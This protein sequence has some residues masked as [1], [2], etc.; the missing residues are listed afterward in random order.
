MPLE[1]GE[2]KSRCDDYMRRQNTFPDRHFSWE[3]SLGKWCF[4]FPASIVEESKKMMFEVGAERALYSISHSLW[5]ETSRKGR[6]AWILS[7]IVDPLN[8]RQDRSFQSLCCMRKGRS[9]LFK[10]PVVWNSVTFT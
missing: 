4:F 2:M 1:E 5:W 6:K 8:K 7:K 3:K 9:I 10:I